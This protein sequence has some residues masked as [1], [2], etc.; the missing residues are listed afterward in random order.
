MKLLTE[1]R[2]ITQDRANPKYS[3][4]SPEGGPERF[5]EVVGIEHYGFVGMVPV[6]VAVLKNGTIGIAIGGRTLGLSPELV[7]DLKEALQ[8]ESVT[9]AS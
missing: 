2:A 8:V 3:S 4:S 1:T 7:A 9:L 6:R 5:E